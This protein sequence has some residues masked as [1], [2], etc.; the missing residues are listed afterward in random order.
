MNNS[1]SRTAQAFDL[2]ASHPRGLS[3]TELAEK[4]HTSKSTSSRLLASLVE[5]GLVERDEAQRHFLDVRFWT[6]GVQA[7]RRLAVLDIAR[8]HIAIAV[9]E[10]GVPAY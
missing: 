1:L 3:V 10:L 2:L 9:R 7:A 6:W 8:P 4:L 5:S